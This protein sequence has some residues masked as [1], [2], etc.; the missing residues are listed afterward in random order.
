[1]KSR[2]VLFSCCNK[3]SVKTAESVL[4]NDKN[5]RVVFYECDKAPLDNVLNYSCDIATGYGEF[6]SSECEIYLCDMSEDKNIY[7]AEK[8]VSM[9]SYGDMIVFSKEKNLDRV[10]KKGFK[11]RY[12]DEVRYCVLK[13]LC[14]NNIFKTADENNHINICVNSL[15]DMN[16][17]LV[18]A[19][20]WFLQ[21]KGYSLYINVNTQLEQWKSFCERYP[22]LTNTKI[23]RDAEEITYKLDFGENIFKNSVKMEISDDYLLEIYDENILKN[24]IVEEIAQRIFEYW[25]EGRADFWNKEY[26]YKTSTASAVFWLMRKKDGESVFV[27]EDNMRLE[28][29]RWNAFMRSMGYRYGEKRNDIIKTH[30]C[31][32]SFDELSDEDKMLDAN[33]IKSILCE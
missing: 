10:D 20:V 17:E 24:R 14:C 2:V 27:C 21:R 3:R 33:P 23:L 16:T 18:K 5:A 6:K 7:Y 32:V 19:V 30:P 4:E 25:S 12:V 22:E 31:I 9:G 1:M 11:I 29:R 8:I 28:H 13:Y 15:D 26:D